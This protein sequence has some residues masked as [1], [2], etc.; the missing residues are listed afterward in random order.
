[1]AIG[2]ASPRAEPV[3]KG[4]VGGRPAL[5]T[6]VKQ[7][8]RAAT[9]GK[10]P[11][12]AGLAAAVALAAAAP[13]QTP[14][15]ATILAP[16][17]PVDPIGELIRKTEDAAEV[18]AQDLETKVKATL[19]YARIKGMS[20]RDSLGCKLAPMRTVAVDPSVFPRHS[21]LFIKETVGMKLPD[22]TAHDGFWYASDV[23]RAIKGLRVDLFTGVTA[24]SMQAFRTL[25][26][27]TISAVKVGTFDG[28][29]SSRSPA[30]TDRQVA[31]NFA[32]N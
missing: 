27:A 8:D 17:I 24:Q 32:P 21:V 29:P 9:V 19:Y 26:L 23:G 30:P 10:T 2:P 5:Y 13:P 15:P 11:M 16:T 1:V 7:A 4:V 6:A 18:A 25:N 22:G 28:C 3:G 14:A 12:I 20:S 31:A